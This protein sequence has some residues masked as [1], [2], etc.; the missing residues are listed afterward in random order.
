MLYINSYASTPIENI[1]S[2]YYIPLKIRFGKPKSINDHLIY[3]SCGD[4][5]NIVEIALFKDTKTLYSITLTNFSNAY[6]QDY[7]YSAKTILNKNYCPIF[8]SNKLE[9]E[10]INE[11]SFIKVY[12]SADNVSVIFTENRIVKCMKN[13]D[14][15]FFIDADNCWIGFNLKITNEQHNN[16]IEQ[17]KI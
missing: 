7:E 6:L 11:E 10:Y 3:W 4:D 9:K 1:D 16:L 17:V 14:I 15:V 12:I 2:D 13:G 8:A 5:K